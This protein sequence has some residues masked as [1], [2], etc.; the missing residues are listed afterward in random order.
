MYSKMD[1]ITSLIIVALVTVMVFSLKA[2]M[3]DTSNDNRLY[4]HVQMQA[5]LA[6]DILQEELRVAQDIMH[7]YEV[8]DGPD[9]LRFRTIS[10]SDAS[11]DHEVVTLKVEHNALLIIKH[12]MET[13]VQ[14][15]VIYPLNIREMNFSFYEP[16]VDPSTINH[17]NANH[18]RMQVMTESNP[19][20]HVQTTSQEKVAR[21][22]ANKEVFLRNRFVPGMDTHT[23]IPE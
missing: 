18:I 23:P 13:A 2:F 1:Y 12:H 7:Y 19:E 14:D 21:A 9:S 17:T 22:T 4:N 20:E 15:T 8:T 5:N 10:F 11:D 3:F 16:G 6:V